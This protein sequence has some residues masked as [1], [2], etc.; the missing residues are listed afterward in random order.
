MLCFHSTVKI[1]PTTDHMTSRLVQ[2]CFVNLLMHF[3]CIAGMALLFTLRGASFL[4][5]RAIKFLVTRDFWSN[6]SQT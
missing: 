4:V 5:I 2:L 1:F 3:N 6:R